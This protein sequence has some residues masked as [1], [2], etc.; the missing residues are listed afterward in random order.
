MFSLGSIDDTFALPGKGRTIK[1][2][3]FPLKG[4]LA[5]WTRGKDSVIFCFDLS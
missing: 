4:K 5:T 1:K 2:L 3:V